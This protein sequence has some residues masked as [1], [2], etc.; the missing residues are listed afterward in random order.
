MAAF[1]AATRNVWYGN[2]GLVSGYVTQSTNLTRVIL[3]N[4]GHMSPGDAPEAALTMMEN[5]IEGKAFKTSK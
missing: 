1:K 2:T 4:A 5:F 3:S